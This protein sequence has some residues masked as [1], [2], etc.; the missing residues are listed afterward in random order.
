MFLFG[1]PLLWGMFGIKL[2]SPFGFVGRF[3][4]K[5]FRQRLR[6]KYM[7]TSTMET[8]A[9]NFL[10]TQNDTANMVRMNRF[11]LD[12][13][14]DMGPAAPPEPDQEP[15]DE[16]NDVEQ[17]NRYARLEQ[18]GWYLEE[19]TP[20]GTRNEGSEEDG[21]VQYTEAG[22]QTSEASARVRS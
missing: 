21:L 17:G 5:S 10:E 12:Y 15:M 14:L 3:A 11:L 13:V 6:E 18:E 4:T 19:F 20:S 22:E 2:I 1:R 7:A 8:P 16:V 9:T